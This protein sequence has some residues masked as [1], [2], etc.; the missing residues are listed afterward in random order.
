MI[1]LLKRKAKDMNNKTIAKNVKEGFNSLKAIYPISDY[2]GSKSGYS[3]IANLTS[4]FLPSG[5]RILDLGCGGMD[6]TGLLALMGYEMHAADDF[7]DPW[8]LRDDNL[9]KLKSF[10]KELGITITVQDIGNYKLDYPENYF[11]GCMINDVIEHL[12]ES[13]KDLL[14]NAGRWLREGGVLL[15]TMPNSVN[16]RKRL[17]VLL[18]RSNYPSV[19]MFYENIGHWRGHVREYTLAEQEYILRKNGFSVLFS[20]TY[21]AMLEAKLKSGFAKYAYLAVCRLLPTLRD[22]LATVAQKPS[23][24][25]PIREDADVFRKSAAGFVPKGVE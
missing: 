24:W 25:K 15:V 7:Q 13:P 21:H 2:I 17:S 10:A 4:R 16:L 11:D 6:K 3:F 8:H 19:E 12:H 18:G 9:K 23:G 20:G 5:G 1:P 22:S 14:N